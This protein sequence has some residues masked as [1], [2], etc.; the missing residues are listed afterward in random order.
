MGIDA[1]LIN[2]KTQDE[3]AGRSLDNFITR[4]QVLSL[5]E[6]Y[7]FI[8][9]YCWKVDT[10]KTGSLDRKNCSENHSYENCVL[11]C[12]KCNKQRSNTIMAKFY[13]KKLY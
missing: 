12:E 9:H 11:A 6:K 3:K 4:S 2:Y 7:K 10:F 13:R 8:C 5:L 1:K